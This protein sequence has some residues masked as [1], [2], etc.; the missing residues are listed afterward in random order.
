MSGVDMSGVYPI[1]L[2]T[3]LVLNV[4][5]DMD[6]AQGGWTV[7]QRRQDGAVNF[8]RRWD[9]YAFGFGNVNGEFWLGNE[10]IH[11]LTRETN[12]TLRIDLW[13]WD[14]KRVHAIYAYV[15][16]CKNSFH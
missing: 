15:S 5:C 2:S 11:I 16:F 9:D 1:K 13:D 3:G 4:Y 8:T 7:I 12:Y 10:N 6:T 14:N